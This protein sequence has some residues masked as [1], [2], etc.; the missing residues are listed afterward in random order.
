MSD[1]NYGYDMFKYKCKNLLREG[2]IL[3]RTDK[4]DDEGCKSLISVKYNDKYFNII[5]KNGIFKS[6]TI[7]ENHV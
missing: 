2:T 6:C 7:G 4:D 1:L 5:M 3:T